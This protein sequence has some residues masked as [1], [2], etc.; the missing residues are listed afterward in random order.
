MTISV[1]LVVEKNSHL[2]C[3][4]RICVKERPTKDAHTLVADP[5]YFAF[6]STVVP[7]LIS[8]P[9]LYILNV[10]KFKFKTSF[11]VRL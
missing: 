4:I 10:A 5:R 6:F 7:K 1:N 2:T 3:C 11:K 9:L 8:E